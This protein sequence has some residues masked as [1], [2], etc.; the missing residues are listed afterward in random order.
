MLNIEIFGEAVLNETKAS[1]CHAFSR[2]LMN[3]L[4]EYKQGIGQIHITYLEI[5]LQGPYSN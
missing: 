4:S 1:M 2:F 5:K 3:Q